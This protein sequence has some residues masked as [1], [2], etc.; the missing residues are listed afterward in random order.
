MRQLAG[1]TSQSTV[2]IQQVV[3]A[4]ETLT[5]RVTEGMGRVRTSALASN[6]QLTEVTEV[7]SQIQDSAQSVAKT[8]SAL[9]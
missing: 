5:N 7:I 2:E 9:F 1:R 6:Q 8:V 4:N 3:G